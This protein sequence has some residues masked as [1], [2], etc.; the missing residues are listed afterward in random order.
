MS[1]LQRAATVVALVRCLRERDGWAGETQI[2]KAVYF[3]QR[4]LDV[5]TAWQY[6]LYKYGPF[7][8]DLRDALTEMRA[9]GFLTLEPQRP[10]YGPRLAAGPGSD[11]LMDRTADVLEHY[12]NAVNFVADRLAPMAVGALERV[13]TALFVTDELCIADDR[14]RAEKINELKPHVSVDEALTSVGELD[15][16][17][18]ALAKP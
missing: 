14:E 11:A 6:S 3:L 5:P 16:M 10:P 7:S 15:A 17:R 9:D 13:A 18:A 2:Q 12:E 4:L 1:R 8:F